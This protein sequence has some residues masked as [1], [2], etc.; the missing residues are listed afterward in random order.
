MPRVRFLVEYFDYPAEDKTV[1]YKAGHS[2]DLEPELTRIVLGR[3]LA[4]LNEL[5]ER[6]GVATEALPELEKE[7]EV[8]L[9]RESTPESGDV[10]P[11]SP[12]MTGRR[13]RKNKRGTL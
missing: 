10:I 1:V 4:I 7:P 2:Y 6:V 12:R 3:G 8:E 11:W 13:G 9:E 5:A